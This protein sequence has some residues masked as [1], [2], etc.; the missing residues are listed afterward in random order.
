M[1]SVAP[2]CMTHLAASRI[3][4]PLRF[5]SA[6]PRHS[7]SLSRSTASGGSDVIAL[8]RDSMAAASVR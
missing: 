8:T 6:L 1:C 7:S 4:P 2:T 3:R 5:L